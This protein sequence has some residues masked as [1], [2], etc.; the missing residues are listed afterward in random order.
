MSGLTC[1]QL[2][3]DTHL[4]VTET[5]GRRDGVSLVETHVNLLVPNTHKSCRP[6]GPGEESC[7][8]GVWTVI[9]FRPLRLS[10]HGRKSHELHDSFGRCLCLLKSSRSFYDVLLT[11]TQWPHR[12]LLPK[13][14]SDSKII[15]FNT[16]LLR[17]SYLS[18]LGLFRAILRRREWIPFCV[19]IYLTIQFSNPEVCQDNFESLT[20][21]SDL[22][23]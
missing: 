16:V 11:R 8:S 6:T 10:T 15:S 2:Y 12:V 4:K 9:R 3:L 5:L 17:T 1:V 13:I 7:I 21:L 18:S 20:T 14:E 22:F 23:N 19:S